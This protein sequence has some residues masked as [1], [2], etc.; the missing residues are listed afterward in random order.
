MGDAIQSIAEQDYPRKLVETVIVDDGS[1]D[2]T[3]SV[4]NS[5]VRN[6]N[7]SAKVISQS[8]KG[9]GPARNVVLNNSTGKYIIWVDSDMLLSRDFVRK[10][11]EFMEMHSDVG[12]AKGSYGMYQANLVS[13]LENIEFMTTN[14]A[15][16]RKIDQNAFGTG[17]SIYRATAIKGVGGFDD[18]IKGSGEDAEAEYRVKKA[19]WKLVKTSAVFFE[20]RRSDW[21]SIWEEYFWHGRGSEQVLRRETS[22]SL[23][24]FLPPVAFVVECMRI[25]VAYKLSR[26]KVALL[27]PLFFA[28]KRTAWMLGLLSS[29]FF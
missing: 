3:L 21:H 13:T 6:L 12:I 18:K 15:Q 7:L 28:F 8:W 26:K 23:Y 17:G 29:R 16:M 2:R 25:T 14:S 22:T 27:L 5:K 19:G 11:V 24:K 9:L 20:R 1:K 10:Q 4:V